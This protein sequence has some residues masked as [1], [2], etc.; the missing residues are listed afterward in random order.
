MTPTSNLNIAVIGAGIGGL[1]AAAYL[2][3]QG[4]SVR[5]FEQSAKLGEIGAGI[6]ISANAMR[7]LEGLGIRAEL[8]SLAVS[9]NGFRFQVHDTAELLHEVPLGEFHAN[10]YGAKYLH[11]HRA[12]LH[13]ALTKVVY[14]LDPDAVRLGATAT[15]FEESANGATVHFA[16][17]SHYECDL[18]VGADGI[19]STIRPQIIGDT[20]VEFTGYVAWRATVST[21]QFGSDYMDKVCTLWVGPGAHAVV[22]YLRSGKLLNFVGIVEND[23]WLEESWTIK[24]SREKL[25]RDFRGWHDDVQFLIDRLPEDGCYRW[26]LYSRPPVANWSTARATLLGDAAHS[27]LPFMAQGA[28]MAIEDGAI[29][30]RAL[31]ECGSIGAALEVYEHSR[32]ER[33]ARIQNGSKNMAKLY[34]SSSEIGLRDR[35]IRQDLNSEFGQWL[36]G[37]DP[38]TEPLNFAEA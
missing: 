13:N 18:L 30:S 32:F 27:T 37:Y 15:R 23:S 24:D 25:K 22:Y 31:S 12:D 9:P 20:P 1:T 11:I 34:H 21:D 29:L 35:F 3:K 2:L 17:G 16:D 28:A 26:A 14:R 6:Q 8:E 33:T 19:K 10:Q 7:V 38:L 4:H 36:Y 5:V